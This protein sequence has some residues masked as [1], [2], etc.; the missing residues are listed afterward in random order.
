VPLWHNLAAAVERTVIAHSGWWNTIP[1]A[2]D[3]TLDARTRKRHAAAHELLAQGVGLLECA[4]RLGWALNTI[5]RY[6][7]AHKAE[8]FVAPATLRSL[9]G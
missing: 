7:R 3:S 1:R 2:P 5:K 4:R 8:E 6:A 9:P